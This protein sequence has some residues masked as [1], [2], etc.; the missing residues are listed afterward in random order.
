MNDG[1]RRGYPTRRSRVGVSEGFHR[2]SKIH[3][4]TDLYHIR[5]RYA[6]SY[7]LEVQCQKNVFCQHACLLEMALLGPVVCSRS[8]SC[9]TDV[10]TYVRTTSWLYTIQLSLKDHEL[11]CANWTSN[12]TLH[13]KS[14]T[15][16]TLMTYALRSHYVSLSACLDHFKPFQIRCIRDKWIEDWF[17]FLD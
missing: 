2:S 9:L 8:I 5:S 11:R 1:T 16:S 15:L 14:I 17:F 7:D 6:I 13:T 12:R 10:R 4:L 3:R